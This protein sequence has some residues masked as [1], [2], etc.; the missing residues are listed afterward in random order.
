MLKAN[1]T[2]PMS[3]MIGE[4]KERMVDLKKQ[5]AVDRE[6]FKTNMKHMA[7]TTTTLLKDTKALSDVLKN[8]QKRGRHAEIGLERVLEMSGLVKGI[9]YD[10]Q[11]TSG[12]GRPDFVVRLSED[13]SIIVDSKAPLDSLWRAFDTDDEAAK[14]AA[15][16]GHVRAVR[17]HITLLSKRKYDTGVKSSL[18]YIVMVMPEYALLPAL[19]RDSK[20]V[21]GAFAIRVVLVTPSTL[22]ILLRAVEL[23]WKQSKMADTVREIGELSATLHSRLNIFANHYNNAGK[24]LATAVKNYNKGIGL[25]VKGSCRR[26]TSSPRPVEPSAP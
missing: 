23:M 12:G 17:G 24:G 18:D 4:L 13:R 7:Y 19:D 1:A 20:L 2:D 8:S 15:L 6:T 14:A 25:G 3:K 16:D 26:L 22:M 21:E 11:D 9:H 10:T 5:N